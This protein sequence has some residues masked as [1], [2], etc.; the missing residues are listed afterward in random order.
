MPRDHKVYLDDIQEAIDKIARYVAGCSL[1]TFRSEE[2]TVDAVL[3]NLGVIGEAVRSVPE[4][5]RSRHPTVDCRKIAGLRDILIH[6]Y[7]GVDLEI[8]WDIIENKL[9]APSHEIRCALAE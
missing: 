2:R 7:F 3:R 5:V 8:I 9:P 1:E 6:E 4:D